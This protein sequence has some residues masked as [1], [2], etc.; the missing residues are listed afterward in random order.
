MDAPVFAR[1]VVL[2]LVLDHPDH[3]IVANE[4]TSVHNLLRL[5]TERRL[6]L[7]LLTKHVASREMAD[8]ELV[9]DSR[10]L[11][12]FALWAQSGTTS[13]VRMD[14]GKSASASCHC[15]TMEETAHLHQEVRQESF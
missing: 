4:T 9:P 5:H 10:S 15:I 6:L 11:G 13:Y 12:A 1:L 8:A 14:S 3:D 7:D 2:Q